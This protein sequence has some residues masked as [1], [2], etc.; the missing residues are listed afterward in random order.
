VA[1]TFVRLKLRLLRNGLGIGQAGV[2]FA[3]GAVSASLLAL[4][5]FVT[6]ATARGHR[7][8]PDLA[9]VLFGL[10][11]V[12]WTFFPILGFGNDETLDPQ[13]LATIPL[14]RRQL[15]G[16]VLAASLVGVA[17]L[18]TLIAFCGAF[19]GFADDLTSTIL[20]A[21]VV[22]VNLLLCVVASRTLVALLVPILRSRRGRDFTILAVTILGLLPPILQLFA[23][24]GGH[25]GTARNWD[26]TVAEIAQRV[27]FTPFAWGGTAIGDATGGHVPAAIGLLLAM[28]A[29]IAV[30]LVIWARALERGLSSSDAPMAPARPDGSST[31]LFPR[32]LSFLPRNRVG[33]NT[34]K[35]LRYSLRDPRRRA[36]LIGALV[37][38]AVALWASLSQNPD[39]P[40]ATTLLALVAVLPA[41]GLTLNQFG[42]DGTAMWS[43]VVAGNDPRS[44]LTGKNIASVFVMVPLATIATLVCAIFTDGWSYVPITLGLAPAIFGVLLGVGNVMSV[45]VPYAMPDR[46]NPLAFSPGQGCATLLAGF[47]ALALEGILLI[48]VAVVT[49]IVLNI[50]ALP[51]ATVIAVVFANAYGAAI[52]IAGRRIAWRDAWWR[53]PEILDAVSPRQ[54]G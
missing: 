41:A 4:A 20:I 6:L 26:H 13:R 53:L 22:V 29:L 52:W 12:G 10:A 43:T 37:I 32:G 51:I 16:G 36:P 40:K 30:L 28:T 38:P 19:A 47:A 14:T 15:V 7:I 9:I 54:A 5:A 18:A 31:G 48:P 21:A 34:A 45:R 24:G 23:A 35:D 42:L 17:P 25:G 2:L 39:R 3:L 27:R 44:D 11:T 33:A 50:T 1:R 46:R 49:A 8:G